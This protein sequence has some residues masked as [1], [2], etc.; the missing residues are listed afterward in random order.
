MRSC[1]TCFYYWCGTIAGAPPSTG[2][3]TGT[4]GASKSTGAPIDALTT[5]APSTSTSGTGLVLTTSGAHT[6]APGAARTVLVCSL[7]LLLVR[8]LPGVPSCAW[9]SSVLSAH[10]CSILCSSYILEDCRASTMI[11]VFLAF[12]TGKEQRRGIC[13]IMPHFWELLGMGNS[14][15]LI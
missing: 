9:C 8:L 14:K 12:L 3:T 5:G 11:I 15:S 13:T 1:W 7:V 6:G 2:A 10:Y 4:P